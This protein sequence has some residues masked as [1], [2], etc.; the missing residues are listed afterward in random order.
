MNLICWCEPVV[1]AYYE[2]QLVTV[3]FVS[4]HCL[5]EYLLTFLLWYFINQGGVLFAAD[6]SLCVQLLHSVVTLCMLTSAGH[7]CYQSPSHKY[8][9]WR[10]A[11]SILWTLLLKNSEC[12]LATTIV[13]HTLPLY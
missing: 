13:Y 1:I 6:F 8:R 2:K 12:I 9:N 10:E 11:Q 5:N 4:I 7:I 3:L